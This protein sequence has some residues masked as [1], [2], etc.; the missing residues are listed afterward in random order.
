MA[1]GQGGKGLDKEHTIARSNPDT[2]GVETRV[3]TQREWKDQGKQLR[4]DGWSRPEGV[5]EEEL[6]AEEPAAAEPDVAPD[7]GEEVV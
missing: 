2:G 5:E 6:E 3:I 4:A 1:N 7:E